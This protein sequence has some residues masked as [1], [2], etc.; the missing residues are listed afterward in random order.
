M[1]FIFIIIFRNPELIPGRDQNNRRNV[2]SKNTQQFKA[3]YSI[4]VSIVTTISD[5]LKKDNFLGNTKVKIT[6]NETTEDV[7]EMKKIYLPLA[8][9]SL[10]IS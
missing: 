6:W 5:V 8:V 10:L 9:V 1:Y 2:L 4:I 3:L 7:Y